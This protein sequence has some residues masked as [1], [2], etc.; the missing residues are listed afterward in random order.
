M[1]W[2]RRALRSCRAGLLRV[3]AGV[4]LVFALAAPTPGAVR[5]CNGEGS[6]DQ[7]ANLVTYCKEREQLVCVRRG[8]R[9]KSSLATTNDC[10]RAAIQ[11]CELRSWSPGCMPTQRQ[12]RACLN[13]LRSLDTLQTPEDKIPECNAQALCTAHAAAKD[14]GVGAAGVGH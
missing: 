13:A 3:C 1:R 14:A 5:S 6:L 2:K 7:A 4:A 10:R 8:L 11:Q 12:T 9:K